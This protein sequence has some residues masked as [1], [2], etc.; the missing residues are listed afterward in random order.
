MTQVAY[1]SFYK[2]I[3]VNQVIKMNSVEKE[4]IFFLNNLLGLPNKKVT[5]WWREMQNRIII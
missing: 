1:I 4:N 2:N 3:F 5:I